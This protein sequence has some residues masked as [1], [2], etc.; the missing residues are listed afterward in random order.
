M[1][2]GVIGFVNFNTF[3]LIVCGVNVVF[4]VLHVETPLI[5]PH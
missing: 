5:V 3:G 1:Q 2:K 4:I